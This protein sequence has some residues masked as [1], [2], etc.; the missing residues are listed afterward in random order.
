MLRSI[1]LCLVMTIYTSITYAGSMI[2]EHKATTDPAILYVP[3]P[4]DWQLG[5]QAANH[6]MSIAEY[7]PKGQT[8]ENWQHMITVQIFN[9]GETFTPESFLLRIA[10]LAAPLC[11]GYKGHM[12]SA[13]AGAKKEANAVL[14]IQYCGRYEKT[15]QGEATLFKAIKGTHAFYVV[16]QAWRGPAFIMQD[17]PIDK[18]QVQAWIEYMNTVALSSNQ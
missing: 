16:Q 5:Y 8:V 14:F 7:V 10:E 6:A 9:Q 3:I 15:Q 17:I 11:H 4:L 2:T 13:A 1:L 18:K 12:I